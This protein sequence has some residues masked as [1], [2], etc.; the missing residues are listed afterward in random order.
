[1]STEDDDIQSHVVNVHVVN[2]IEI[3][4]LPGEQ[5]DPVRH[6]VTRTWNDIGAIVEILQLDPNRTKSEIF[7]SGAGT[8]YVCHSLGQAQAA[9][10]GTGGN[11][12]ALVPC[13]GAGA[14]PVHWRDYSQAKV[15]AVLTG[16][17]PAIAVI[18]ERRA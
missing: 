13:P 18:S 3:A 11:F 8:V 1:V 4:T 5:A 2:P 15:W 12:G 16:A 10:T 9:L 7:V 6:V 17:S 14:A